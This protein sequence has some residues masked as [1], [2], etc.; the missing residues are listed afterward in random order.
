MLQFQGPS[1]AIPVL[2]GPSES[3]LVSLGPSAAIQASPVVSEIVK[4]GIPGK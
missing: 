2:L 1:M 4:E 3:I